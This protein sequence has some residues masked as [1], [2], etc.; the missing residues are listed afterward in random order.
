MEERFSRNFPSVSEEEQ[1]VLRSKRVLLVGCGGLGGHLLELMVRLGVGEITAVDGDCFSP[2]N[3]NRQLL[4]TTQ[5]LGASKAAEAAARAKAIFPD[6]R[7]T[8]VETFLTAENATE[9]LRGCD[10]ALDALDSAEA[11]LILEDGCAEAGV[12]LVHGAVMGWMAQVTVSMPGSGI[13]H[14][15][16]SGI[17]TKPSAPSVLSFTPALCASLQAAEATKLLLGKPSDLDG[18]LLL[19]DLLHGDCTVAKL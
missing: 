1:A 14:R 4:S 13:L 19:Y 18:S 5:N 17:R 11:R 3:L 9:L 7:V 16:Y 10:L 12:P 6:A 8:P 15:L 2:S